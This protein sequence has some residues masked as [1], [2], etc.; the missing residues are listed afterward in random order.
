MG[1]GKLESNNQKRHH[2]LRANGEKAV[3]TSSRRPT[4]D[5]DFAK[6]SSTIDNGILVEEEQSG[7]HLEEAMVQSPKETSVTDRAP[8]LAWKYK[9]ELYETKVIMI[10]WAKMKR[11]ADGGVDFADFYKFVCAIFDLTSINQQ[12]AQSVYDSVK[13]SKQADI[14]RFLHYY[15][16]NLFSVIAMLKASPEKAASEKLIARLATDFGVDSTKIDKMWRTFD[17]YDKDGS[18]LIDK[19]EF[20]SMIC[21]MMKVKEPSDMP[22]QRIDKFWQE[23]DEDG[24]GEVDFQEFAQWY[25][26]YF[27]SRSSKDSGSNNLIETFYE[28]FSPDKQR[29]RVK[30]ML[31]ELTEQM[32]AGA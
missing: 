5:F 22:A 31:D 4:K 26:K 2:F 27:A 10:Q 13:V 18:G 19:G 17:K 23:I 21:D 29:G 16:T 1:V 9:L 7:E 25:L 12:M 32:L 8:V 30:Q 20:A 6:R 11:N 15:M 3:V 14:E 28:S 24:S